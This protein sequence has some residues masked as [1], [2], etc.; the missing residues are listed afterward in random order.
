MENNHDFEQERRRLTRWAW[1][2]TAAYAGV[3]L[4]LALM[5]LFGEEGVS[6]F[7]K[8]KPNAVG[9]L[10]AG[11]AGPLAFIWLVYGYFLQGISIR[12]QSEELRQNTA[13]LK[14]Q[15]KALEEQTKELQLS[16]EQQKQMVDISQKQY[17]ASI[18]QSDYEK[19]RDSRALR[20]NFSIIFIGAEIDPYTATEKLQLVAP[21]ERYRITARFLNRGHPA[22]NIAF[23]YRY[24]PGE[25]WK[26]FG[27]TSLIK[28]EE[29]ATFQFTSLIS[30][31]RSSQLQV[32]LTYEDGRSDR[33]QQMFN[34]RPGFDDT[35]RVNRL[36][37]ERVEH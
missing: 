11:I 18:R 23:S 12:Q 29:V 2:V 27:H 28:S 14:I 15:G 37:A 34:I 6:A 33:Q 3:L 13:A 8:M 1:G 20:A 4:V 7:R 21:S 30:Q 5:V 25:S 26:E 16:V 9:D 35:E 19:D 31:L 32:Q 36:E 22:G 10:L 17:N 24:G